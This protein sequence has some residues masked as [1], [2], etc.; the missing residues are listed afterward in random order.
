MTR[1]EYPLPEAIRDI[2]V[3]VDAPVASPGSADTA[4]GMAEEPV[5]MTPSS[6]ARAAMTLMGDLGREGTFIPSL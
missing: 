1:Q 3:F 4:A 2:A 5:T 6:S